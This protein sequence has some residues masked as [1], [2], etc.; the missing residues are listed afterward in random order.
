MAVQVS[1]ANAIGRTNDKIAYIELCAG[2]RG[3]LE[4]YCAANCAI[5]A[6]PPMVQTAPAPKLSSYL[7]TVFIRKWQLEAPRS[8]ESTMS[9]SGAEQ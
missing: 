2:Y 8:G 5:T 7:V 3:F 9:K 6:S 4:T 1:Q